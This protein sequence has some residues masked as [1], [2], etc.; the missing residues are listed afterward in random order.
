MSSLSSL[1][2]STAG[3]STQPPINFNGLVS[4]LDTSS[5]I[6]GLLAVDQAQITAVTQK[7]TN[8]QAEQTAYKQV[9]AQLLTLQ[10]DIGQLNAPVNGVFDAQTATS[11]NSSVVTAAASSGAVP[12]VYSLQ[13]N[14][15]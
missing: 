14:S 3:T 9:E 4:G 8:V 6:T 13:V 11:S 5:L 1:T 10:G 7:E 15:L 12:G 2:S